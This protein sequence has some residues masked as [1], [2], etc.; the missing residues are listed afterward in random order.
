[1]PDLGQISDRAPQ[2]TSRRRAGLAL[3]VLAAVALFFVGLAALGNVVSADTP[4]SCRSV[5][6]LTDDLVASG[7]IPKSCVA[8]DTVKILH[9]TLNGRYSANLLDWE[10]YPNN[11]AASRPL[12][13]FR[14]SNGEPFNPLLMTVHSCEYEIKG[15]RNACVGY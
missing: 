8:D 12:I 7:V 6:V 15:S 10:E 5:T 9:V 13:E 1:M 11:F 4:D 3:V 14:A 2:W